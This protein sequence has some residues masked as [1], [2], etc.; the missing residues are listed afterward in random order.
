M[1]VHGKARVNPANIWCTGSMLGVKIEKLKISPRDWSLNIFSDL[2]PKSL[3]E[4]GMAF[5][6][7]IAFT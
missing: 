7:N 2:P 1:M 4:W 3:Y 6:T 5:F